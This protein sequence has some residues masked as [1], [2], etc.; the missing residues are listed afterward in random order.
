MPN[1]HLFCH[2]GFNRTSLLPVFVDSCPICFNLDVHQAKR[3]ISSQTKAIIPVHLF[4]QSA[5]IDPVLAIAEQHNLNI[6]EDAA[7]SRRNL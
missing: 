2:G 7:V 5:E 6:I 4:G 1:V 3:R